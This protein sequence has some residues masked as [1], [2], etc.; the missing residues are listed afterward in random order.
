MKKQ[1][2]SVKYFDFTKHLTRWRHKKRKAIE[3][4]VDE[5]AVTHIIETFDERQNKMRD[6]HKQKRPVLITENIREVSYEPY[7]IVIQS[8]KYGFEKSLY[9][10]L[11]DITHIAEKDVAVAVMNLSDDD[12]YILLKCHNKSQFDKVKLKLKNVAKFSCKPSNSNSGLDLPMPGL[13][14]SV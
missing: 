13:S 10:V 11:L 12:D 5:L 8:V 9:E 2:C 7:D 1:K 4:A 6:Y 14:I 3:A